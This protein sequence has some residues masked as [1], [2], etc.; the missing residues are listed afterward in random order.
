MDLAD[1]SAD[2]TLA[3]ASGSLSS[4][5]L[6]ALVSGTQSAVDAGGLRERL[7]AAA[8][9][10][11]AVDAV[12][13]A[14]ADQRFAALAASLRTSGAARVVVASPSEGGA[15]H[16]V[17]AVQ[18]TLHADAAADLA[19]ACDEADLLGEPTE[20]PPPSRLDRPAKR[21][22]AQASERMACRRL[23]AVP[24]DDGERSHAVLLLADPSDAVAAAAAVLSPTLGLAMR[25]R[26]DAER[27]SVERVRRWWRETMT[28]SRRRIATTAT[29]AAAAVLA[30]PMPY[31]SACECKVEPDFRRFVAA[32]FDGRLEQVDAHPG[33]LVTAGQR[34]AVM[35]N[36]EI[37]FELEGLLAERQKAERERTSQLAR[38]NVS[39]SQIATL[40]GDRIGARIDVLTDRR[41]RL[42][43]TAPIDGMV[44]EGDLDRVRGMPMEK[45]HTLFEIAPLDR[46]VCELHVAEYDAREIAVGQSV[47]ITLHAQPWTTLRGNVQRI[48]PRVEERDGHPAI[49]AEVELDNPAVGEGE[50]WGPL[51]PGMTGDAK[52]ATSWRPLAW[53]WLHR[54]YGEFR[55]GW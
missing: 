3:T 39:E 7:A 44:V 30:M 25:T 11:D 24:I 54:W 12:L 34:L 53:N 42:A 22:I 35:D 10:V 38:R 27:T 4:E 6:A 51:R 26:D 19:A 43:V 16:Q 50:R 21:A 55:R 17:R 32:P 23:L 2:D 41:E 18:P 5:E 48:R 52:I 45:G 29:L 31:R 36:R 20:Y 1:L 14:P 49:I 46:V 13:A 37:E 15:M 47:A 9:V 33:D 40:E 28:A 8:V